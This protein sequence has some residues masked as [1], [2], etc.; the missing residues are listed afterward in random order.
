MG[1]RDLK[2]KLKDM[3]Q[4]DLIKVI[5]DLYKLNSANKE[6]LDFLVKPNYRELHKRYRQKVIE[7]FYPKQG[8][9]IK[10]AVGKKAISDFKKFD[11]PT[12]LVADLMLT[13]VEIG[14]VT[15]DEYDIYDEK[16]N[17]SILDELYTFL[18]YCNKHDIINDFLERCLQ[19]DNLASNLDEDFYYSLMDL[20]CNFIPDYDQY[21]YDDEDEEEEDNDEVDDK[22][23]KDDTKTQKTK[24]IE[25]PKL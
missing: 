12:I 17:M 5:G 22:V 7:A 13:Y 24:I 11:V 1:L 10:L 16:I 2:L 15:C 23:E 14:I 25:F 18:K 19:L 8:Y 3:K 9:K 20:L 4:E 21:D 6:Y